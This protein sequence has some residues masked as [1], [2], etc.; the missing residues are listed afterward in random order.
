MTAMCAVVLRMGGGR[1]LVRESS[2]NQEIEVNTRCNCNFR[3]GDRI[4]ILFL[5]NFFYIL[6]A[7]IKLIIL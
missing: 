6:N 1:L 7:Q 3:I 5:K 4:I 2:T